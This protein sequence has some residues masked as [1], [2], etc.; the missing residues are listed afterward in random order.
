M[1]ESKSQVS[2]EKDESVIF[3]RT[4]DSLDVI[5]KGQMDAME[6]GDWL[7]FPLMGA[8]T[9]ATASE[10]NGF[11]KPEQLIDV[12]NLLPDIDTVRVLIDNYNSN[13]NKIEYLKPLTG[14]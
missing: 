11:P 3:G 8:Y 9:S 7:Y 6:V 1:R 2:K 4:C 5:A 13:K 10:F 12:N 14:I